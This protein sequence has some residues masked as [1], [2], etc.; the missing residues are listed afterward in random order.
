MT[1]TLAVDDLTFQI[2]RSPRRKTVELVIERDGM[3]RLIAPA[4][5]DLSAISAFVR[6]KQFWLFGKLAEK[7]LLERPTSAKEYVNGEGFS[8]LG[9]QYRLLL[10]NDQDRPLKLSSGRFQLNRDAVPQAAE[11]F[12]RWYTDHAREWICERVPPWAR[13]LGVEPARIDVRDLGYR[14]GSCGK[15]RSVYFHWAAIMGPP[16]VV[17]YV[18]VHELAHLLESHHTP[19]FWRRVERALPDYKI[20]KQRLAELGAG[21]TL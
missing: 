14:W 17:D 1:E 10:V 12:I 18:I 15:G 19:A 4:E 20:R 6:K 7:G 21:H 13:R 3:L 5:A 11:H 9:R 16:S 2:Q 8:Y